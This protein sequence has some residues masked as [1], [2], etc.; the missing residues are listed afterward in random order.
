MT[1]PPPQAHPKKLAVQTWDESYNGA[2]MAAAMTGVY[3]AYFEAVPRALYDDG[4]G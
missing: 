3:R 4:E 1:P 2:S